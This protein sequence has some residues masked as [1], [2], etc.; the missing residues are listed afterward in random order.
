VKQRLQHISNWLKNEQK[1][2]TTAEKA[3]IGS[4]TWLVHWQN[5]I[6]VGLAFV[7]LVG[8]LSLNYLFSEGANLRSYT[9]DIELTLH[10]HEEE[11]S[12]ISNDSA[13]LRRQV[14]G[15]SK[16][17]AEDQ[18]IDAD[19]ILALSQR[20]YN[21]CIY[22][23]DSL[24]LWTNN[25]VF[26]PESFTPSRLPD[27]Q[28]R[29]HKNGYYVIK[30]SELELFAGR[31]FDIVSLVPIKNA[32]TLNSEHLNNTFTEHP[33]IPSAV[34]LCQVP[35][36][37]PIR[38]SSGEVVSYLHNTK[39]FRD[40]RYQALLLG[41]YFIGFGIIGFLL[42]NFA[43]FVEERF[44]TWAGGITIVS[45]VI[46]CRSIMVASH[47][48]DQFSDLGM[49]SEMFQT[50]VLSGSLGGLLLNVL[51]V[52]WLVTF[53]HRHYSLPNQSKSSELKRWTITGA[54]YLAIILSS[55]GLSH[56]FQSSF[57][58]PSYF[59]TD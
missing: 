33:S 44:G 30:H 19:R 17:S 46:L 1:D 8:M 40:W 28:L 12:S 47:W 6:L 11:I 50:P 5:H 38:A 36:A 9:S 51:V 29:R 58:E 23:K 52:L 43:V 10:E 55:F 2:N 37:F 27:I 48:S 41:L 15:L 39:K 18:K 31:S 35:T 16:L 3:E 20:P 32:Y 26:L 49:F 56:A 34:D 4:A 25:R 21:L 13:F 57:S 59:L 53:F 7:L 22:E 45:S 42:N 24:V 14:Y 54:H